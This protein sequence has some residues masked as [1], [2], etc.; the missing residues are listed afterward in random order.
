VTELLPPGQAW[1]ETPYAVTA[2][3]ARPPYGGRPPYKKEWSWVRGAVSIAVVVLLAAGLKAVAAHHGAAAA[4]EARP[5][6]GREEAGHALG[7][8]QAVVIP[9]SSYDLLMVQKDG[10]T[11]VTWSPCRPIHWVMR[12]GGEPAH[13]QALVRDAFTRLGAVTGL[14]FVYDG[15]TDEEPRFDRRPYQPERYGD[16]W[17][18]VLVTWATLPAVGSLGAQV[19]GEA[20]PWPVTT[21]NGDLTY[22]TG[23]VAIEPRTTNLSIAR[24]GDG[25]ARMIIMHELGHLMGLAHVT[26][27]AQIMSP[28][29]SP[30]VTEYQP[31]DRA[32]LNVLASG[33]CRPDV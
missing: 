23:V 19:A 31:G 30:L 32:G 24:Y 27:S 33:P 2:Q 15:T 18:P 4:G 13:G 26:D 11:P 3:P 17:A 1:G 6:A 20:M 25:A 5:T 28:T 16:R 8:P 7:V 9:S 14:R 29:A 10:R 12:P 21:E 22:V